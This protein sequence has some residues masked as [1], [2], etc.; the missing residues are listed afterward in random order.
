[1]AQATFSYQG[2]RTRVVVQ[3]AGHLQWLAEFLVPWF[4][5]CAEP[6]HVE[7]RVS[8]DA[9]RFGRLMEFGGTGESVASFMMDTK[10]IELPVWN[11]PTGV[12]ALLEKEQGIFYLVSDSH[13]ELL[14]AHLDTNFRLRLMRVLR[15][16]AMGS[17]QLSG[18]RF[19]HAS[20]FAVNGK[21]AIITGPRT[22]G[23]TT[24]LSYMLATSEAEFLCNDRLLIRGC[25]SSVMARGMPTIVSLREGTMEMIPEMRRII[26][27][28]G[29]ASN[30]T[31]QEAA[32]RGPL[33][34]FP[35]REG[36]HG[37]SP[38]QYCAAV[39][40]KPVRSARGAVLIFPR[41]NGARSKI[42][43]HRLNREEILARLKTCLFGHI[44]PDRLSQAFTV[45]PSGISRELP[46]SDDTFLASLAKSLPGYDC[47]MGREAYTCDD[48]ARSILQILNSVD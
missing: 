15:E 44:G 32:D 14:C 27:K 48:G 24:L 26:K 43:L 2:L 8:A 19:L 38:R 46:E 22:A 47:D 36:R 1:M 7:V 21:A 12:L 17:A 42:K 45:I 9:E 4:R 18:G 23:K 6:P 16:L 3:E 5:E 28:R 34:V 11:D 30:R 31:L 33:E 29:Y 20:A 25:D 13:I 10:C 35:R 41:Q 40:C 39:G 37:V